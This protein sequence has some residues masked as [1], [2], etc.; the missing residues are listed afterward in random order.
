MTKDPNFFLNHIVRDKRSQ[1]GDF[2]FEEELPEK[3][4]FENDDWTNDIMGNKYKGEW[5]KNT[6]IKE[7][8]GTW[9]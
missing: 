9:V 3:N 4:R 2:T 6:K 5:L 8:K 7:G 1:M